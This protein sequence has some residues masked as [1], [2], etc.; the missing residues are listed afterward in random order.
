MVARE[1]LVAEKAVE[2]SPFAHVEWVESVVVKVPALIPEDA[3]SYML[4]AVASALRRLADTVAYIQSVVE[5][6]EEVKRRAEAAEFRPQVWPLGVSDWPRQAQAKG[7][8]SSSAA[9]A[10][11]R[12]C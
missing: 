6:M 5:D 3:P 9:E 1:D 8:D 7:I 4:S 12:G 11:L 10:R 2:L